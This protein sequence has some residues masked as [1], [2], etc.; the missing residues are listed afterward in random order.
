T[1][2]AVVAYAALALPFGNIQRTLHSDVS[3]SSGRIDLRLGP[4]RDSTVLDS[5]G[6]SSRQEVDV[7]QRLGGTDLWLTGTR[8]PPTVLLPVSVPP[9][10]LWILACAALLEAAML[11]WGHRLGRA[12]QRVQQRR[13]DKAADSPTFSDVLE[14]DKT[15][16]AAAEQA[17]SGGPE[18]A[19]SDE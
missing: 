7:A 9:L 6:S 2:G 12:R 4:D 10:A 15:G 8:A 19:P 1:D 14:A 11:Q 17:T 5:K 16:S 18:A 13:V 3:V